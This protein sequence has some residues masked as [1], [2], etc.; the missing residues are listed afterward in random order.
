MTSGSYAIIHVS[1]GQK[2]A[3]GQVLAQFNEYMQSRSQS[4]TPAFVT[5]SEGYFRV[6]CAPQG[7]SSVAIE[8]FGSFLVSSGYAI[9][10]IAS[11]S[12][13]EGH[14]GTEV[15]FSGMSGNEESV[16]LSTLNVY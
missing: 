4:H 3:E 5:D 8:A 12:T 11:V 6:E 14:V 2:A 7:A 10:G 13:G 16:V 15:K 9:S 1:A